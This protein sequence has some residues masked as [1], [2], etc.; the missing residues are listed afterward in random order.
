MFKPSTGGNVSN[1]PD[2]V[3]VPSRLAPRHCGQSSAQVNV[4]H[5][6]HRMQA[7]SETMPGSGPNRIWRR[8]LKC[9][10]MNNRMLKY[11]VEG[12]W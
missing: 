5:V 9:I 10:S 1:T 2:S 4:A 6:P 3:Q 7:A 12:N 11:L 8:R